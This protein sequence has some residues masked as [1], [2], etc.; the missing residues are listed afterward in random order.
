MGTYVSGAIVFGKRAAF[1]LVAE[2]LSASLL[3]ADV[4]TAILTSQEILLGA[5]RACWYAV[6]DQHGYSSDAGGDLPRLLSDL[7]ADKVMWIH[8]SDST[9]E[10][11]FRLIRGHEVVAQSSADD[12]DARAVFEC[13][14]ELLSLQDLIKEPEDLVDIL[15]LSELPGHNRW[16]IRNRQP[17]IQDATSHTFA[18]AGAPELRLDHEFKPLRPMRRLLTLLVWFFGAVVVLGILAVAA[19]YLLEALR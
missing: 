17:F 6:T 7:G 2:Q 10:G 19:A 14:F 13:A 3:K 15:Q 11:A 4:R 8:Y 1:A 12:A 9:G 18:T 5:Q 16:L